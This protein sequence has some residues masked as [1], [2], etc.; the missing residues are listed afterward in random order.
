MEQ[1]C[2]RATPATLPNR[3]SVDEDHTLCLF[4]PHKRQIHRF[5][6]GLTLTKIN[7]NGNKQRAI[8]NNYVLPA[9][10]LVTTALS[11]HPKCGVYRHTLFQV[12]GYAW[13]TAFPGYDPYRKKQYNFILL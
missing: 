2:R 11:T 8:D 3:K 4:W 1:P 9:M 10:S 13:K 6:T 12:A 5:F 7:D